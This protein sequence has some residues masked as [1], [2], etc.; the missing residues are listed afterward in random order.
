[1]GVRLRWVLPAAAL[2][3]VAGVGAAFAA[4]MSGTSSGTVKA[5]KNAT[6]GSLLVTSGGLTLYHYTP[7][8]NGKIKCTGACASFWPPLV[9]KAGV[10]PTAGAGITKSKLSTMKRP[11]GKTQV[12]YA[13]FPLYRYAG[14]KKPGDVKGQGFEKIW[15]AVTA[16]GTLAKA[17]AGGGTGTTPAPTPTMTDPYPGGGY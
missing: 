14:D 12:T 2:L 13:G 11:D 8:K 15:F 17:G 5:A 3:A 7:D 16:K 4:T 6:F 1:M 10:K 9:V